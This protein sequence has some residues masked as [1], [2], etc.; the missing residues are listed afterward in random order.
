MMLLME[1][2]MLR[3]RKMYRTT[4]LNFLA[5]RMMI[6]RMMISMIEEK[7]PVVVVGKERSAAMRKTDLCP[8]FSQELVEISR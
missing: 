8:L 1:E 6:K 7:N 5:R 3:G 4:I 2:M